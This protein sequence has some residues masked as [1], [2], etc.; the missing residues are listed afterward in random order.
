V[1][2]ESIFSAGQLLAQQEYFVYFN[3]SKGSTAGKELLPAGKV[4]SE[5]VK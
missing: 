4:F 1:R 5:A 3:A 2:T